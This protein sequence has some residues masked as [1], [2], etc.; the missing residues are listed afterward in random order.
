MDSIEY[1]LFYMDS[2]WIPYGIQGEGKVLVLEGHCYTWQY[3]SFF[4]YI[5]KKP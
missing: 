3:K 5:L 1:F 4:I 2:T